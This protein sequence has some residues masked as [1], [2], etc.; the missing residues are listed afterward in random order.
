LTLLLA[1]PRDRG[2]SCS[3]WARFSLRIRLSPSARSARTT[4]RAGISRRTWKM[5]RSSASFTTTP[6]TRLSRRPSRS[7]CSMAVHGSSTSWRR[8]PRWVS[9]GWLH[10]TCGTRRR[11]RCGLD[12]A[13]QCRC[14]GATRSR[15]TLRS[16]C[17]QPSKARHTKTHRTLSRHTLRTAR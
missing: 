16:G 6:A 10:Q 12:R 2:S 9:A 14:L 3:S 8:P 11:R 5:T 17:A 7:T 15:R 1:G 13:G 4:R